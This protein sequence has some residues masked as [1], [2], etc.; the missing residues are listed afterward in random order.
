MHTMI[1]SNK[2]HY[3]KTIEFLKT[4]IESLRT[5]RISPSLVETIKVESYGT[6]SDLVQLASISAPEPQTIAIKPWDKGI[7]KDIERAL[8]SSDLNV[9]PVVDSDL[10]R[11]NFPALTEESRKDLVKILHKKLEET[12]ITL[13]SQREKIKDTVVNAEKAKEIT[14][15]DRFQALKELDEMTKEYNEKIKLLGT[16]KEQEIMKV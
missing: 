2:A 12:R 14:E 4:D 9:N 7:L 11:L 6:V 15:D 10:V 5:G 3:D 16:E 1:E 8:M 13:K